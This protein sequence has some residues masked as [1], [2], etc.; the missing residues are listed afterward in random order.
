MPLSPASRLADF[1]TGIGTAGAVLKVDNPN[2]RVGIG[3]QIPAATLGVAGIVSAT[4]FYGDGSNLD[5]VASAGLGTALSE[6]EFDPLTVIYQTSDTLSVPSTITVDPPDATSKVAYTQYAEI[7]LEDGA[8]LIVAEGDDFIPDILGLSTE[9]AGGGAAYGNNV[10]NTVYADN[11]EKAD[12]RGAPN[13][14]KGI[15]VSYIGVSTFTGNVSIAGT[16]TYEDVTNVD[17]VGVVTA[18]NGIDV[19]AGG[20]D[21]TA[22]AITASGDGVNSSTNLILKTG[23]TERVRILSDGKTGIGTSPYG[24]SARLQIYEPTLDRA[25]ILDSGN[26]NGPHMR[27]WRQGVVQH[28]IGCSA[29][30]GQGNYE[31]L[32]VRAKDNIIFHPGDSSTERLRIGAAGQIGLSG[33]NYGTTGQVLTSQGASAAP[34]WADSGGVWALINKQTITSSTSDIDVSFGANAGITTG[35]S[36]YKIYYDLWLNSGEYAYM[37]GAYGFSGTFAN[38][39]KTSDYWYS[40]FYHRAGE[41]AMQWPMQGENQSSLVISAKNSKKH[42]SGEMIIFNA[43]GRLSSDSPVSWPVLAFNAQGFSGGD[44]DA[45]NFTVS[46]QLKGGDNQPLQGVRIYGG[47]SIL[48]GEVRTYGLT[49]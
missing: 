1:G 45:H 36:Q 40:G 43:S 15:N 42:H 46:G 33:A 41:T 44:N 25:L 27:L 16:L 21:V 13:F 9:G 17:S 31:D 29:G 48:A 49:V 37:R 47:S 28:Y 19:T 32:G 26:A 10:F 11:I 34:Q 39:V 12:G 4:A 8:D 18:R 2:K 38:D 22:G 3:T 24:S 14:P 35:Y 5:G 6:T 7:K 23:G 20:I 30:F